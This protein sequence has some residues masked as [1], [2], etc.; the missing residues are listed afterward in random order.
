MRNLRLF[1][2]VLLG[3]IGYALSELVLR[4]FFVVLPAPFEMGGMV[5]AVA[6]TPW[7]LL[8]LEL[9]RPA[10][11]AFG[12]ALR[13]FTYLTLMAAGVALNAVLLNSLLAWIIALLRRE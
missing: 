6:S 11:T 4:R 12:E 2:I 9:F 7:S 5:L 8:A 1:Q 10:E 13:D 3:V